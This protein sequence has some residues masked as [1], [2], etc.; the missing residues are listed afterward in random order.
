MFYDTYSF[1][2]HITNHRGLPSDVLFA[3]SN[4]G[5]SLIFIFI[6]SG[7]GQLLALKPLQNEFHSVYYS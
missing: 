2:N 6:F 3:S 5:V 4:A 7:V 1:P